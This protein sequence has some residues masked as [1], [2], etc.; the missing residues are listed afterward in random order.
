MI[1]PLKGHLTK[2]YGVLITL[3]GLKSKPE[4]LLNYSKT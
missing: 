2:Q 4:Y 1:I 3:Y